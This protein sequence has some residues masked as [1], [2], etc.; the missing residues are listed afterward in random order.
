MYCNKCGKAIE[1]DEKYCSKCGNYIGENLQNIN[2]SLPKNDFQEKTLPNNNLNASN[3][4]R[5]NN[6]KLIFLGMGIGLGITALIFICVITITTLN[7]KYYFNDKSYDNSN[8]TIN[9]SNKGSITKKGKYSTAIIYDNTYT[10][11]EI[12]NNKD[13]YDLI[14]KDSVSQKNNC[15]KE[16]R[17]IEDDI[18]NKYN[19][20][21]VNLCEMDVA[22]AKELENA[23]AK[24]YNE[25][26]SI[27]GY[28]TNLTLVNASLSN[29]YIAAFMPV[30]NFATADTSSTY[31]WV[32][33]TQILLNTSYFLNQE[34]LEASVTSGSSTG[35][36]PPNA[37]IYSPI[38]H[39]LG[40]YL[41]FLA[42]MNNYD[43]N[44]ILLIDNNNVNAFYKLYDD[45][46]KGNYSYKMIEE[47]YNQYKKDTNT[48]LSLDE[49][50]GTISDYALAKDNSGNYI[51]DETIAE[52]FHDVYLNENNA[53]DASKYIVNVLKQKLEG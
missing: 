16:I 35:H 28:I 14:V 51:Y 47:A 49:W 26:P 6:K 45:F 7:N 50:R 3:I 52:A 46:G 37:T 36:F 38:V 53:K 17:A 31:P 22:F 15:P 42:M 40:H 44:S 23:L 10:G 48:V 25:Y 19:I 43:I 11:V 27:R 24:I 18:I 1:P 41:S 20:T 39:E 2:I 9:T 8:E 33:K 34:R 29:D 13:A 30:F 4:K 21:A 32:I 5:L 12:D